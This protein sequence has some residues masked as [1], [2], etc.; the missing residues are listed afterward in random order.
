MHLN[1]HCLN[2][3]SQISYSNVIL[4]VFTNIVLLHLLFQPE[5]IIPVSVKHKDQSWNIN[6]ISQT[7]TKD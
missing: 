7:K 5:H 1:T 3:R 6:R 2:T 4:Y